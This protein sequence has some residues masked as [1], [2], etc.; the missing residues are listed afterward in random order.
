MKTFH[1]DSE[2]IDRV[3]RRLIRDHF[4]ITRQALAYWRRN[5][6]PKQH[7]KPL[8]LLGHVHGKDMKDLGVTPELP[9]A[10]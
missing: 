6:V 2:A 9:N 1:P 8:A 4:E 7:R 3:G 10:G 5:G